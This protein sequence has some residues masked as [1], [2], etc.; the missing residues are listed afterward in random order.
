MISTRST[1]LR[2]PRPERI[3]QWSAGCLSVWAASTALTAHAQFDTFGGDPSTNAFIR[4]PA[5]TDDWTRHFRLGA[6]V[7]LNISANFA[8]KGT[9][10]VSGNNP[11]AGTF[12]DGYVIKNGNSPYTSDW[13]YSNPTDLSGSTLSL[14]GASGFSSQ[15]TSQGDGGPLPGLDLAYGGNL[16]YWKHAR[17]GWDLGFGWLPVDI[18]SS[19]TEPGVINSITYK[20]S[21]GNIIV[22]TAPGGTYQ[23]GS[24][25]YGPSI[26][27]AY[28]SSTN[29]V[30]GTVSGTHS[31]DVDLYTLRLG[32]SF[33][34]DMTERT[35]VA[36]GAG[37]AIG[38]VDG[39]YKYSENINAS[40]I[41]TRNTGSV[42]GTDFTFGGYVNATFL[43]HL[44]NN[45][46]IYLGAQYMPME[47]ATISGGGRSGE[48][49]LGGQLYFSLGINW[50]F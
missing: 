3:A 49:K 48:L 23:G 2:C 10:P 43:Y 47:D 46:D 45:G 17:V 4:I 20:F 24:S 33:F 44:V 12:G 37:P 7:G 36:F 26:P 11:A 38:L 41:I 28:T 30:N 15:G 19:S 32:P 1:H 50:P 5:D 22:P 39:E 29:T 35:S 16:W 40:G 8:M 9:F 13:G 6:M 18:S 42:S 34:W 27:V 31:M 25:G 21:T 14:H